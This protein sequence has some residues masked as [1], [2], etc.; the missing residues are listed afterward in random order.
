M[1]KANKANT[2]PT[3]IFSSIF[4]CL[5]CMKYVTT[6]KPLTPAMTNARTTFHTCSSNDVTSIVMQVRNSSVTRIIPRVL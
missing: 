2:M 5:M 4:S 3:N 1:I 6:R